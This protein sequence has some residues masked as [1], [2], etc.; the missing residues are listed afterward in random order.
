MVSEALERSPRWEVLRDRT[1]WT[2]ATMS[3]PLVFAA[4]TV[5]LVTCELIAERSGVSA[6]G[7]VRPGLLLG[8]AVL[9]GLLYRFGGS[10]VRGL[11]VALAVDVLILAQWVLFE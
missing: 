10:A 4:L 1:V 6:A 8:A 7:A 5:V 3:F 9:A 2:V 11:A